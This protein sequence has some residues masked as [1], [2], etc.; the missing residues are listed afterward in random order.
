[1]TGLFVAIEGPKSVGKSSLVNQMRLEL[2]AAATSW[3]FTKE[4][5]EQFDL[6]HEQ[7][8][9]GADL[10]SLI[11]ED[12]AHHRAEVIEPALRRGQIVV[13][14]RYVLSSYVFHC[15]DGVGADVVADLNSAFPPPDLLIILLCS[16]RTLRARRVDQRNPSRFTS[17][18]SVE[19]ELLGYL[20]YAQRCRP[21]RDRIIIQYNETMT[22]RSVIAKSLIASAQSK[23][24]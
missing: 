14:D 24:S 16:P 19:D 6:D 8:F 4:P 17:A 12:R 22:D 15:L 7:R 1:M 9:V 21:A 18:I 11:A 10:A 2:G 20:E 13:T 23:R 3:V 5:T